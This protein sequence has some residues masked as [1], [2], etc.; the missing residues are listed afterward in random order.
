MPKPGAYSELL[1]A[2]LYTI[3]ESPKLDLSIF[4]DSFLSALFLVGSWLIVP[5]ELISSELLDE[6]SSSMFFSL[7]R[8]L[9]MALS[10][11]FFEKS[12]FL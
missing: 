1:I 10:E 3:C 8:L 9:S 12:E 7:N 4:Y 11:N 2:S 6:S 5:S